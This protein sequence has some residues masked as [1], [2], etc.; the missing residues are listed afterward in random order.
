MGFSPAVGQQATRQLDTM[1]DLL[2]VS[3]V[4]SPEETAELKEVVKVLSEETETA[5]LT[6]ERWETI[7]HLRKTLTEKLAEDE[8]ALAQ[9]NLVVSKLL[10]A[11]NGELE[12]LLSAHK[13]DLGKVSEVLKSLNEK[14]VLKNLPAELGPEFGELLAQGQTQLA[15]NPELRQQVFGQ[16]QSLME[17]R[18][19]DLQKV[20]SQF[21]RAFSQMPTQSANGTESGP[22]PVSPPVPPNTSD[23]AQADGT[24]KWGNESKEKQ[25]KFKQVVLPPGF[26]ADP[27][28]QSA[29][30]TPGEK[31]PRTVRPS[32]NV[33]AELPTEFNSATGGEIRTRELRPRHRA[34]VKKY[35][36]NESDA[37]ASETI[38][39]PAGE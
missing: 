27:T 22:S 38:N 14:G 21:D 33:S 20:R 15:Q 28:N 26:A 7:D 2:E 5:P 34:V 1:I 19:L 16:L 13:L 8:T 35:F 10:E 9:A 4:L 12:E 39:P 18:S 36:Q 24:L 32:E 37:E 3:R 25:A 31:Q 11:D 23:V 29:G 17:N 6:S 30:V